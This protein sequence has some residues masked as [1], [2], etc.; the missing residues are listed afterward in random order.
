MYKTMVMEL[1]DQRPELQEELRKSQV[2]LVALDLYA[3]QLKAS[4][5]AW[6]GHLARTKPGSG[7]IQTA[8]EALEIALK[9]LEDSLTSGVRPDRTEPPSLDGTMAFIRGQKPRA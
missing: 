8:S 2:L 3:L 9:E 1:L 4:H 7:E 6:K 5:E